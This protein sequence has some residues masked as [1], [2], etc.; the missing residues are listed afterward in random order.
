MARKRALILGVTGQ[1]G[2]LLAKLLLEKGYQVFGASRSNPSLVFGALESVGLSDE[3]ALLQYD[4]LNE[5]SIAEILR[6]SEPDEVY[7]LAG[8]TSVA[9]S[10]ERPDEAF[11]SI[12]KGTFHLVHQQRKYP[13]AFKL[14]N[15]GSSESFGDTQGARADEHTA[16]NPRSPYGAAKAAAFWQVKTFRE[17]YGQFCCSG[18]LFNHESSLRTERFV[19]KKIVNAAV[20]IASGSSE[21]LSLGNLKV[22]RDWGWA[23]EYVEA[24]WLMLQQQSPEDFVIGTGETNSLEDFTCEVFK[25]LNLDWRDHVTT[26]DSLLRPLDIAANYA[27]PEKAKKV[28]GWTAKT[29]MRGVIQN[30]I[31]EAQ[32]ASARS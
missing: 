12:A 23:P 30:L 21:K 26:S 27:N 31:A 19:T 10:F 8:L 16:L 15:A 29:K 5:S 25:C 18:I 6:T 13:G 2:R 14:Y 9:L 20:R 22:S 28:L 4:G 24:M 32:R 3:I 1:D 11:S 7:N 17:S